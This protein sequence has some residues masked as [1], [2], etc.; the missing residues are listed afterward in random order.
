MKNVTFLLTS[1]WLLWSCTEDSQ[2][3]LIRNNTEIALSNKHVEI[4]REQ[5][6]MEAEGLPLLYNDKDKPVATQLQDK[7]GDDEWD[8]IIFQVSLGA[9]ENV[10]LK[11]KWT[12]SAGY[13]DFEKKTQI[14]F[15]YS[16]NRDN[17]YV[18][19]DTHV[20]PDGHEPQDPPY[21]YQFEGPG[22]ENNLV[23]Y[24][25]YFDTRNGKDIFGKTTEDMVLQNVA[26][27][28][29]YHELQ[30]WG[31][32]VLKV[33]S[34]LGAG[35]LALLKAD[36]LI[37]LGATGYSAFEKLEEGPVFSRLKLTYRD[38]NIMGEMYE[39]EEVITI[40]ANKRWYKSEITLPGNEGDTLVAG[41]VNLNEANVQSFA[42]NQHE[43]LYTFGDQSE[44][45]DALGM[46]L[47]VPSGR[48]AGVSKASAYSTEISDSE[49]ALMTPDNNTYSFY[50]FAGWEEENEMFANQESF[51]AKLTDMANELT[52]KL[53]VSVE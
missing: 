7:N 36:S 27:G 20:R 8:V 3:V 39:I 19:L 41:I 15:G 14:Y 47:V 22:W 34:S 48:F 28:E 31:M 53:N 24:R 5:L 32:D 40:W 23:G 17:N 6:G 25:S 18:S 10:R 42:A 29:N 37:R 30:P 2:S 26:L 1:I 4:A 33:G 49:L 44:N 35:S 46:A 21:M 11:V 38:W 52:S 43:V 50:F 13:P 9:G 16:E 45:K 51:Q 12:D